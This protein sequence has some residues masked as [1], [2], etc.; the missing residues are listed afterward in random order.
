MTQ[1]KMRWCMVVAHMGF[2][3]KVMPRSASSDEGVEV[4]ATAMDRFTEDGRFYNDPKTL[5]WTDLEGIDNIG[6]LA[7][8][9]MQQ[10][11][12]LFRQPRERR[13]LRK[14]GA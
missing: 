4:P 11:L 5:H 10:V 13:R 14:G 3:I 12:D 2:S 6:Q 9:Y 1:S 7:Q 8:P